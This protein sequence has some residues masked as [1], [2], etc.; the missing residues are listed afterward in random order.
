MAN[1]SQCIFCRII[2]G[3]AGAHVVYRDD[4]VM[5]FLD[6]HPVT[7]GHLLV[8]P[9]RHAADLASLAPEDAAAMMAAGRILGRAVRRGP[10]GAEGV[11]LHLADGAV[12]GQSVFHAHLHV[13][14]RT[15]GDGFGFR[16]PLGV[17]EPE[18]DLAELA[19]RIRAGLEDGS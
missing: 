14:P 18:G 5:A 7:R 15:H 16:R 10:L 12:A 4:R 11:N 1:D 2:R 17:A 6:I 19:V 8:V 3:E 9:K 13:I